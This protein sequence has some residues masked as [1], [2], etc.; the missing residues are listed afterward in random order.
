MKKL[1]FTLLSIGLIFNACKKKAADDS[2]NVDVY[3]VGYEK[4]QQNIMVA[5]MWKNGVA[6]SLT[7]GS[8]DAVANEIVVSGT[9]VYIVGFEMDN[10]AR[11]RNAKLWKNGVASEPFEGNTNS[12]AAHCA[13]ISGKNV[14]VLGSQGAP[15]VPIF[16]LWKNGEV[17]EFTHGSDTPYAASYM[18]LAGDDVYMTG[19]INN[20][21]YVW[22]NGIMTDISGG[23]NSYG[24]AITVSNS[25]VYVA[26]SKNSG[27]RYYATLWKN[28]VAERL[29][30]DPLYNSWASS[31]VVSGKDVYVAGR[32]LDSNN[33]AGPIKLWK[34]GHE[35][36]IT[37]SFNANYFAFNIGLAVWGKDIYV[38]G[39]DEGKARIWKNGIATD[40]TDGSFEADVYAVV[41]A[42][43]Q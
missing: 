20:L 40:L 19:S 33:N 23:N 26:G 15:R 27:D 41:V 43:K 22:K 2:Q 24:R 9:D 38:A 1:I 28:G 32:L 29:N 12:T 17:T 42:Q 7:D 8:A 6:T 14:Y 11:Y 10:T 34:N 35:T 16:L 36:N 3:A 18:T 39:G 31:V 5:K 37:Y 30:N 25:D 4:N 21:A 13:Y